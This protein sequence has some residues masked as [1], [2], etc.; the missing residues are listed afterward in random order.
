MKYPKNKFE[1]LHYHQGV[2]GDSRLL[3]LDN[4]LERNGFP[5]LNQLE[6]IDA[7]GLIGQINRV[8]FFC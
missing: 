2:M 7:I 3:N 4:L 6:E 8:V 5:V 1:A